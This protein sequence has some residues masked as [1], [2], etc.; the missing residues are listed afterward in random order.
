MVG[1]SVLVLIK[2]PNCFGVGSVMRGLLVVDGSCVQ[3]ACWPLNS[4]FGV[5][6]LFVFSYGMILW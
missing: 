5:K 2:R 3:L 1:M 6:Q 4:W